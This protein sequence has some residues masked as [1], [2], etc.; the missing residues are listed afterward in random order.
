MT[1][2][3]LRVSGVGVRF[4]GVKALDAVSFE[5]F[6]GE[7]LGL[8]GP[9]GAGKSTLMRVVTGVIRPQRGT[10]ELQ[11]RRLDSVAVHARVRLGLGMSQQLV[12]PLSSMTVLE[13]VTLAAGGERTVTPWRAL[14]TLDR[15]REVQKAGKILAMLAISEH[16]DQLPSALPLGVLKRLEM[17]RALAT[18]PTVLLLDEPLAGLNHL[19][20]GRLADTIV[21]IVSAGTSVILIEHNLGEVLR[22]CTRLVVLDNGRLLAS[23]APAEV[24]QD[25]RVRSA[26]LGEA[27]GGAPRQQD[28]FSCA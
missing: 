25:A 26:Y 28:S 5:L 9:N 16:A 21:D 15:S 8:I 18:V 10:V 12:Q 4:G 23:G 7:L 17:A 22:I 6:E 1:G 14:G 11:G 13:N 2:A 24:M 3:V 19:E 27:A 20:A